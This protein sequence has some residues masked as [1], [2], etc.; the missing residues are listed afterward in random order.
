MTTRKRSRS[1]RSRS[2]RGSSKRPQKRWIGARTGRNRRR[3]RSAPP[4]ALRALAA[5]GRALGDHADDVAGLV[6]IGAAIVTGL[7]IYGAAGG[8]AGRAVGDGAGLAFGVLQF[9][10]PPALLAAGLVLVLHRGPRTA[11]GTEGP[12]PTDGSQLDGASVAAHIG[13]GSVL[14]ALALAGLAH[15]AGGSPEFS[16]PEAELRDAGGYVG[17]AVGGGTAH[18]L[19]AGGAAAVFVLVA[20]AGLVVLTRTPIRV[21]AD[22]TVAGFRP[23]AAVAG[24]RL[25]TLFRLR[26]WADDAAPAIEW[27]DRELGDE[28][29]VEPSEADVGDPDGDATLT[30]G[31][32]RRRRGVK[33]V[34]P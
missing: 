25:A 34:E 3:S 24:E 11:A 28:T 22:R 20:V 18:V 21:A 2:R 12:G 4:L 16:S 8:P 13:V 17:V 10:L 26:R 5:S 9:A 15:L 31:A 14:L 33:V 32:G 6:L 30:G 27:D 23:L 1:S 7:G 19:G 29:V